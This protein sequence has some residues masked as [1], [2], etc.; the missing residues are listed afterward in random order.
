ML[1]TTCVEETEDACE[2]S[3]PLRGTVVWGMDCTAADGV[4]WVAALAA[5]TLL[6]GRVRMACLDFETVLGLQ[7]TLDA[8]TAILSDVEGRE[9]EGGPD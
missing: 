7:P 3:K 5:L 8:A 4:D 6:V 9:E 1:S 2:Y